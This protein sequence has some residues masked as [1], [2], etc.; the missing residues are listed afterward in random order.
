MSR[1]GIGTDLIACDVN[2]TTGELS[3]RLWVTTV[4]VTSA[5]AS[6]HLVP[7][8]SMLRPLHNKHSLD[9]TTPLGL[10]L[11]ITENLSSIL[12]QIQKKI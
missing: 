10:T 2:G 11:Y 1:V 7:V 3:P 6:L 12:I 5:T 4:T 9:N 8:A